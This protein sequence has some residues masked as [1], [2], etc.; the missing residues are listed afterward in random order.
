MCLDSLGVRQNLTAPGWLDREQWLVCKQTV[1][2]MS[3]VGTAKADG[4]RGWY[5]ESLAVHFAV[6]VKDAPLEDDIRAEI[7]M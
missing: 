6:G 1:V 7:R 3:A 2:P 5:R 4:A